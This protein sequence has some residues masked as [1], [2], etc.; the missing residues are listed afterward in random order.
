MKDFRLA[1]IQCSSVCGDLTVNLRTMEE[2]FEEAVGLGARLIVWP[3][4]SLTGHAEDHKE[5]SSMALDL[6]DSPVQKAVGLSGMHSVCCCFGLY[7]RSGKEYYNTSIIAENGKIVGFHRKVHIPPRERNIFTPGRKFDTFQLPFARVGI[8]IC[9]DN[10]IPES[11]LCLALNGAEVIL[12]PTGWADHW[13]KEDY[14]EPCSSDSEVVAERERWMKMMF[15][16]RCRDT[17]TF[18]ALANKTGTEKS[19]SWKFVGKSMIFAP[20]GR[21]IGEAGAWS[22]EIITADLDAELFQK[23]RAMDAWAMR[24]RRPSVYG[25]LVEEGK[26]GGQK[27]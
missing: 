16:A 20:T 23:Y 8:S 25:S 15:G 12:M 21:V 18:S 13:E 3:E 5:V 17:G 19:G 10:E 11:H 6:A 2:K 4:L 1:V 24:G 9:Y 27:N 26:T 14:I 22:D 7:E